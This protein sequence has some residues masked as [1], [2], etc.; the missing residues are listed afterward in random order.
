MTTVEQIEDQDEVLDN[1]GTTETVEKQPSVRESLA[2]AIEQ[3]KAKTEEPKTGR[4]RD[5]AG[6]FSKKEDKPEIIA[7]REAPKVQTKA[8]VEVLPEVKM[9]KS[10]PADKAK[11]FATLPRPI[12]E[13]LAKREDDY[14]KEL[15][16]HDEERNFGREIQKVVMPYMA[17]I[18][19]EGVDAPKA[20]AELFNTAHVLR[21]AS[22]QVKGELLWRTAQAFGADMR[23]GLQQ[24][25][26]QPFN[27]VLQQLQQEIAGL[28]GSI[29]QE[30][31]L[32]QQQ[33]EGALKSQIDTFAAD[34]KNVHFEAVKAHMAALLRGGAAK[35]LQDAYEQAVY[36]NP[37][38]RSTLL[39]QNVKSVE[40]QRVADKKAKA[41]AAKRA[42]S[43][44]KGSPGIAA[45]KNGRIVQ[46][47]LRKELEA[48]FAAHR[49][50]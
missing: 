30:K 32:K 27:P 39:E 26:Q 7:S 5:E 10:F 6:K 1:L 49:D 16:K 3:T 36:A 43:S 25:A 38:T 34:P 13:L 33:E 2:S 42:G 44:I 37:Q 45:L 22:P 19:A 4:E 12:Q 35:D 40:E 8:P 20:I 50:G 48:Q 47:N 28:K 46:P 9:P 41:E 18:R 11:E 17:Q 14:H 23:Q 15:T 21:T 31:A 24:Q 29:E